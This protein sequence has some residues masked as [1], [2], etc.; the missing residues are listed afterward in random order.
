MLEKFRD[1]GATKNTVTPSPI[2][3][4]LSFIKS[5]ATSSLTTLRAELCRWI[6]RF[7]VNYGQ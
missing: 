4:D 3:F 5:I 6:G 7:S 1:T 2:C